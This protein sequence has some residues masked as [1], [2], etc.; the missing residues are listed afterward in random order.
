MSNS[1]HEQIAA[2]CD[3]VAERWERGRYGDKGLRLWAEDTA[4]VMRQAAA[5]LRLTCVSQEA[6]SEFPCATCSV[7]TWCEWQG[8]C[9]AE[10]TAPSDPVVKEAS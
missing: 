5:M 10:H 9:L 8:K 7:A 6:R 4:R 1:S 2:E 3:R